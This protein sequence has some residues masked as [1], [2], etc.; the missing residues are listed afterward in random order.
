MNQNIIQKKK[1]NMLYYN[2]KKYNNFSNSD[3]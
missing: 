3:K 2:S 1:K